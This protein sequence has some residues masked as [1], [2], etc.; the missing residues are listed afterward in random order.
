MDAHGG[1]DRLAG[2]RYFDREGVSCGPRPGDADRAGDFLC[3]YHFR[4]GIHRRRS[5]DSP[6]GCSAR[7]AISDAAEFYCKCRLGIHDRRGLGS[8]N[9]AHAKTYN[10]SPRKEYLK[11]SSI[12]GVLFLLSPPQ[13]I[14]AEIVPAQGEHVFSFLFWE[15]APASV[16]QSF[17]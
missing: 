13:P 14:S 9:R 4:L 15:E 16:P 7:F 12:R 11:N 8:G 5:V 6:S 1:H 2:E 10:L 3:A 17:L